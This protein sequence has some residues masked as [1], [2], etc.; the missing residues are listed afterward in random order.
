MQEE[1]QGRVKSF[2][3]RWQSLWQKRGGEKRILHGMIAMYSKLSFSL[4][5]SAL[6]CLRC[7]RSSRTYRD[8]LG[9][10][11]LESVVIKSRLDVGLDKGRGDGPHICFVRIKY[12]LKKKKMKII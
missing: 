4:V 1:C 3:K 6:F 10:T 12:K 7:T 9:N 11:D 2:I 8:D 5:K